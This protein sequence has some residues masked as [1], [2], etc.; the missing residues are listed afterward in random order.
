VSA[1]RRLQILNQLLAGGASELDPKRLCQACA[2]I[3][4]LRG[5]G[6]M[7]ASHDVIQ[8]PIGTTDEL[9]ALV[10]QLQ[11]TLGEGPGVDAHRG[12]LPVLEPDLAEP[13]VSRWLAFAGPAVEAGVRAVFGFPLRVGAI[14]L[15]ALDLYGDQPGPLTDEQHA[16][17]LAMAG[18]VAQ[19]ILAMQA[20]A[21][22]GTLAA[23]LEAASEFQYVVHQAAGMVSAQLDVTVGEALIRIRG[24]AF[25]RGRPMADVAADVVARRLRFDDSGDEDEPGAEGP[26]L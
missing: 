10:E 8:G 25:G 13:A 14:R 24:Y 3:T 11:Y 20:S 1:E 23:E 22:P 19:A 18:I 5:A 16:D 21:P 15:G 26:R 9:S 4:G 6:I 12:G 17:A 7:L 2:E